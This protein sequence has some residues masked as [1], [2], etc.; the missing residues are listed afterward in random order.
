MSRTAIRLLTLDL[1]DT[2]WPCAPIVQAAEDELYLWLGEVAPEFV[3][4]QSQE[5]LRDHRLAI[6]AAHPDIAHDITAVRLRSLQV[7]LAASGYPP[8]LAERGLE[9]FLRARHRVEPYPE[10]EEILIK[11]ARDFTLVSLTNGNADIRKTPLGGH[12]GLALSAA[13]VGAAKP[14]PELFLRALAWAGVR[15]DQAMHVGD[16]PYLDVEA[17]RRIGMGTAWV[18]RQGS[19]WPEG[20]AL[21]DICVHDLIELQAWLTGA[22][23]KPRHLRRST[24]W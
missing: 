9:I 24:R 7:L 17:A 14:S 2:L 10:V 23:E 6:K 19:R 12:V 22:D 16:D 15:V 11:L 4:A 3:A 21:P 8:A 1:D 5:S 18:N 13:E 20:L